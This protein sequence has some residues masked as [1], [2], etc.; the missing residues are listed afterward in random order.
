MRKYLIMFLICG[1]L[2]F[3]STLAFNSIIL[4]S[5]LKGYI[6]L[7]WTN[8]LFKLRQELNPENNKTSKDIIVIL[9]DD[10]TNV[11]M[12]SFWPYDR[13]YVAK[14][15]KFLT[16]AEAKTIILDIVF[17]IPKPNKVKS[18]QELIEAVKNAENVYLGSKFIASISNKQHYNNEAIKH[19][20]AFNIKHNN[21]TKDSFRFTHN[22]QQFETP[23]KEL[24]DVSKGIGFFNAA[25]KEDITRKSLL[26]LCDGDNCYPNLGLAYYLGKENIK[27][28]TCYPKQYMQIANLNIPI[29]SK[30]RFDINWFGA[31]LTNKNQ[32]PSFFYK[33]KP[34]WRLIQSYNDIITTSK[35]LNMKP[36]AVLKHWND[37][38]NT[39][40]NEN[41]I[42][43]VDPNIFKD[44]IVLIG[45]S[46]SGAHDYIN[47]P[48][49]TMPGVFKHAFVLDN[50]LT[51]RFIVTLNNNYILL[52]VIMFCFLT[53]ATVIY[54]SSKDYSALLILPFAY[55]ILFS[56]TCI[57]AFTFHNIN[58][59]WIL[60]SSSI[61]ITFILGIIYYFFAEGK[62]KKK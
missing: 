38:T 22:H 20:I 50:L 25:K 31:L 36:E 48:F 1:V 43:P 9:F 39:Y 7:A 57:Y 17:P 44:K 41:L 15:I 56:I 3:I 12:S 62:E 2:G 46:S 37:E 6:S 42:L 8:N 32:D 11:K 53:S 4:Q 49:G 61:L 24:M 47:T 60:P 13:K 33:S 58:I 23:F 10:E 21:I 28:M 18:D 30:N 29:D 16:L 26:I 59:N 54:A 40:I 19:A 55:I 5:S 14:L 52:L 51:K 27:E 34:A 35:K 45:V